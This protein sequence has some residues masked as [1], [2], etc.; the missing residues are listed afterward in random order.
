[1]EHPKPTAGNGREIPELMNWLSREE[2]NPVADA[3]EVR[4]KQAR[5]RELGLK[6][7]MKLLPREQWYSGA[8]LRYSTKSDAIESLYFQGE[9]GKWGRLRFMHDHGPTA[10][11]PRCT[12][13]Y[14]GSA[15]KVYRLE[16]WVSSHPKST[17]TIGQVNEAAKKLGLSLGL[18]AGQNQIEVFVSEYGKPDALVTGTHRSGGVI[19]FGFADSDRAKDSDIV[20][21]WF[22]VAR[23]TYF[24]LGTNKK[25]LFTRDTNK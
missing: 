14:S 13:Q 25:H 23:S 16:K 11:A 18:T 3:E 20:K 15:G 4:K 12:I 24:D 9:G 5:L 22:D 17:L 21:S 7:T 6:E 2:R 19:S 8:E 1:M 10:T